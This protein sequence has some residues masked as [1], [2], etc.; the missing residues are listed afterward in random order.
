M[1]T[2]EADLLP[3]A[4]GQAQAELK[5]FSPYYR[6]QFSVARFL[7]VEDDLE[8]RKQKITQLLLPK[9]PGRLPVCREKAESCLLSKSPTSFCCVPPGSS[10]GR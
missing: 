4:A 7:Q 6:R 5:D 3:P 1:V 2:G 9:V 10:S 8:Q